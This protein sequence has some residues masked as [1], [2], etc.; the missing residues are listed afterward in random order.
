MPETINPNARKQD[1]NRDW[2]FMPGM[3]SAESAANARTVQLPHDYLIE[4][5]TRPEAMSGPATGYYDAFPAN[6]TKHVVIPAEW[7]GVEVRDLLYS[8]GVDAKV[9]ANLYESEIQ[10]IKDAG[11]NYVRLLFDFQY[12]MSE[13]P[14]LFY[15]FSDKPQ[16]GSMNETHLKALDQIIAW[17]MERDIHVNLC[18]TDVVGWS[19]RAIPDAILS[20][21]QNA[22]PMAEQWQVLARR[23]AD[24]PNTYLSFTMLREPAI[25]TENFYAQFFPTVVEAIRAESP[26]RCIIAEINGRFTGACMAEMGV[27]L[28]S[29]AVWPE[30]LMIEPQDPRAKVDRL[31][32][33]FT[34]PYEKNGVIYD[35]EAAMTN[36]LWGTASPD[37]VA[38][39]AKEYGVGYM[40]Y[41]WAPYLKY[42]NSVR[43]ERF[44]DDMLQSYLQDL[45]G[46]LADRGYGW[47]YGNWFGFAGFGAAYPAINST[48]YTKITNA[49]LYVDDETFAWLQ[50]IN[51]VS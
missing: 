37:E 14:D 47:C 9:D 48:T 25:W 29:S 50:E 45:S 49:P 2:A 21:E 13:I 19:D 4:T 38:A 51:G 17:C 33:E 41:S 24:I 10:L 20:K 39:T 7:K 28:A 44:T 30:E 16:E 42:G 43:R 46:T 23:Y 35:G 1:L 32:A 11:F 15:I 6:Y 5:D 22:R 40:V 34:W 31:L 8:D 18:C 26:E 27:A 3:Y 36:H 12:L